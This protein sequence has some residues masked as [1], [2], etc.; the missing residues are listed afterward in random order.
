[1]AVEPRKRSL[2][3]ETAGEDVVEG[4]TRFGGYGRR[5]LEAQSKRND[6]PSTGS[7][8]AESLK[9]RRQPWRVMREVK[10]IAKVAGNVRYGGVASDSDGEV[11]RLGVG[12][13]TNENGPKRSGCG[14]VEDPT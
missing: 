11:G 4:M 7:V 12:D 5:E 2:S 6:G 9:I 13:A 8:A 14:F 1:M 3:I 10:E